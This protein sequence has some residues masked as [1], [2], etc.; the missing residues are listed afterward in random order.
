MVG[1]R[2]VVDLRDHLRKRRRIDVSPHKCYS[3]R[4]RES[5]RECSQEGPERQWRGRLFHDRLASELGNNTHISLQSES[6]FALSDSHGRHWSGYPQSNRHTRLRLEERE[7]RR[8]NR[9][10]SQV[11]SSEISHGFDSRRAESSLLKSADGTFSGP[12]TLAQIK[13]ER[14]RARETE[15]N[16]SASRINQ[17]SRGPGPRDFEGPKPLNELLKDKRISSSANDNTNGS[18]G[19]ASGNEHRPSGDEELLNSGTLEKHNNGYE[20]DFIVDDDDGEDEDTVH[21]K[22]R[23]MFSS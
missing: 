4:T 6:E 13:E 2:D 8:R 12:K 11:I 17:D 7:H 14:R 20:S 22:L 1:D 23:H 19:M 21:A 16:R 18:S 5:C 3:S 15:G 10:A 9:K